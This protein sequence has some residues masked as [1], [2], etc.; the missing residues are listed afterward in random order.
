[1]GSSERGWPRFSGAAE[2]DADLQPYAT[3]PGHK[4]T[5]RACHL[6]KPTLNTTTVQEKHLFLSRLGKVSMGKKSLIGLDGKCNGENMDNTKWR[7]NDRQL[8][9]PDKKTTHINFTAVAYREEIVLSFY[10]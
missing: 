7:A 2:G 10:S 8:R 6:L 9:N 4:K 5:L 3:A 1:M